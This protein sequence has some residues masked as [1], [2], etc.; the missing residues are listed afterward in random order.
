MSKQV[1]DIKTGAVKWRRDKPGG[2]PSIGQAVSGIEAARVRSAASAWTEGRAW[3]FGYDTFGNLKSVT[4]PKGVS[5]PAER[6]TKQRWCADTHGEH[7]MTRT[8]EDRMDTERGTD[9]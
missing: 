2:V 7:P 6:H 9:E 3:Q 8:D 4:D 5:T 1:A